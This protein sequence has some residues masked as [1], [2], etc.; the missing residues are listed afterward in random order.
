MIER[1]MLILINSTRKILEQLENDKN[2]TICFEKQKRAINQVIN[3]IK[4][5]KLMISTTTSK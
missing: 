2:K 5:V 1:E 4:V 3:N